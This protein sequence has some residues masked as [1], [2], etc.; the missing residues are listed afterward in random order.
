MCKIIGFIGKVDGYRTAA[1]F[2]R[3][4]LFKSACNRTAT[5]TDTTFNG[6]YTKRQASKFLRAKGIVFNHT[7]K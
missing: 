5:D 7:N 6:L 4:E 2:M 3:T 1:G